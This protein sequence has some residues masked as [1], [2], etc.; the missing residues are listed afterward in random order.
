MV[1]LNPRDRHLLLEN[2]RPPS[3]FKL[4][5]AVGTTYSLDLL[6]LLTAPLAFTFYGWE[7]DNGNITSEP[8]ALLES[9]RR[10]AGQIALF[11][12]AGAI[13]LP[14]YAQRLIAYL[15]RSVIEVLPK[16]EGAI[17]HPKI[18]A[19]RY[20]DDEY[21]VRY[22]LLC[23]SRNLTFDKSWDTVLVLDGVLEDR[24]RAYSQ[25][26]PLGDFI[27]M[28]PNLA[29]RTIPET[30]ISFV[31]LIAN[32]IRRVKFELP[33]GIDDIRFWPLGMSAKDQWPYKVSTRPILIMSPF[34]KAETISKLSEQR[35]AVTLISRPD[36]LIKLPKEMLS[37]ISRK[38]ILDQGAEVL[39]EAD[40]QETE[41]ELAGLHAKLVVIDDGW[42]SRVYTGSANATNAAF[43]GNIEFITELTGKKSNF[44]IAVFLGNENSKE[45]S[46]GDLLLPW[47]LPEHIDTEIDNR[48]E[49]LEKKLRIIRA[50]LA[51]SLMEV[52]IEPSDDGFT[53]TIRTAKPL[54]EL[55]ANHIN[56]WPTTLRSVDAKRINYEGEMLAQFPSVTLEV[57]TG[58]IAFE[59][60]VTDQG[61]SLQDRFVL[62]LPIRNAPKDRFENLLASML[63]DENN[64]IRLIWLLLQSD[65]E[66]DA[67]KFGE[68]FRGVGAASQSNQIEFMP[69]FEEMIKSIAIGPR[70]VNDV[71]KLINELKKTSDGE[72][73]I[74]S[75]LVQLCETM[76]EYMEHSDER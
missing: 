50:Q 16:P 40:G 35:E 28:L 46:L 71:V 63:R 39:D 4:S 5:Y 37:G 15:E 59:I 33:A 47:E 53:L 69:I 73:L 3:G 65:G 7:D 56:V 1:M 24:Q 66:F 32:E 10:H 29:I 70:R 68:I 31:Q 62:N 14:P 74:P 51:R 12:H 25:N 72:K 57:I 42:D 61:E 45:G 26:H 55:A 38:F 17:F 36:E 21:N 6:A 11:C 52:S 76:T 20:E 18:W 41:S 34:L 22:R 8:L 19:L 9:L 13:K 58:F 27:S 67:G 60:R 23:L 2:L 49:I 44:G 75:G 54:L 30:V 43:N 48:L 64:L